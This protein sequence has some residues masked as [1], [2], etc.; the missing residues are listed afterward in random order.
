MQ[1]IQA[2]RTARWAICAN[3]LRIVCPTIRHSNNRLPTPCTHCR[4]AF[5]WHS[6]LLPARVRLLRDFSLQN[7]NFLGF[8]DILIHQ[9]RILWHPAAQLIRTCLLL[10]RREEGGRWRSLV[11]AYPPIL[12]HP[13]GQTWA[14]ERLLARAL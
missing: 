4:H 11:R 8:P 2:I 1:E 12:F 7:N 5:L 14:R 13:V 9:P 3:S 6:A 10:Q